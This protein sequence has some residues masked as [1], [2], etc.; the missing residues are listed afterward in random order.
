MSDTDTEQQAAK[1]FAATRR[2]LMT[3]D[4][5]EAFEAWSRNPGHA[6]ALAELWRVWAMLA[7]ASAAAET[8][9]PQPARASLL[10]RPARVAAMLSAASLAI[11]VLSQ[12]D[13]AWWTTL[14]WWSR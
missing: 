3:Q 9:G 1:W 2:G 14:D 6:A 12:L 13:G 11:V 4:E 10:P 7:P 5:R 8:R